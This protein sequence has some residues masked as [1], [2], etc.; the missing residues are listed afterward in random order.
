MMVK[1]NDRSQTFDIVSSDI[2][3]YED[4]KYNDYDDDYN[5]YAKTS[6]IFFWDL[7]LG[8]FLFRY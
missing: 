1:G 3:N 7:S 6:K 8:L 4:K 2:Q 5:E